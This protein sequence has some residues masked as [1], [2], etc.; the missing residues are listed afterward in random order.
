[1]KH[2]TV[3][4][5]FVSFIYSQTCFKR[6]PLKQRIIGLLRQ[7]TSLKRFNS[8]MKFSMTEQKK[9]YLLIE[10]TAWTGLTVS[11]KFCFVLFF[12]GKKGACKK[13]WSETWCNNRPGVKIDEEAGGRTSNV[14][15]CRSFT[16]VCSEVSFHYLVPA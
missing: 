6:S 8:Y 3:Y 4:W 15:C 16:Q 12:S 7:V 1:M 2:A 11:Y 5:H 14:N 10:V 9:D 13:M